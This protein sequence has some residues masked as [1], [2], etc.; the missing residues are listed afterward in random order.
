MKRTKKAIISAFMQLL[1]EKSYNKITVQNIA[2][3]C[4]INRNTFYYHFADIPQ[5]V[6]AALDSWIDEIL[7]NYGGDKTPLEC[8]RVAA[9][10]CMNHRTELSHL[11]R[12]TSHR[13]VF[14]KCVKQVVY[15]A[16]DTYMSL[17]LPEDATDEEKQ[18]HGARVWFY[19]CLFSGVLLDWFD[20]DLSYDLSERLELVYGSLMTDDEG[21]TIGKNKNEDKDPG[22]ES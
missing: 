22:S 7:Q 14:I 3:R 16:V 1:K 17:S 19:Q 13:D 6:E 18:V 20:A 10:E 4:Q 8:L 9:G 5:L 15:H 2:E 11:Y 21:D 12:P